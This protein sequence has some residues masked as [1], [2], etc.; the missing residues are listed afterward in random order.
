MKINCFEDIQAW[1]K[2]QDP[3]VYICQNFQQIKDFS[4]KDQIFHASVS[5]SNNIAEGFDRDSD[6]EFKRF[7]YIARGSNSEV[8][9]MLYLAVRLGYLT[10]IQFNE[11]VELSKSTA[12]LINGFITY[13]RRKNKHYN[14][15]ALRTSCPGTRTNR[16]GTN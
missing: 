2:A 9:S 14:R 7:L 6:N 13:L 8:K 15:A 5:V 3:A 12:K 4:F 1:Q 16:L 10:E 11:G